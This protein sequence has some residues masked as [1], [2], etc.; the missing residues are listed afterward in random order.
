M[1]I[2]NSNHSNNSN[3]DSNNSENRYSS[4]IS[5]TS[6]NRYTSNNSNTSKNRYIIVIVVIMVI[7]GFSET[8]DPASGCSVLIGKP[9]PKNEVLTIQVP[10]NHVGH[11]VPKP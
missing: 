6:K 1:G 8:L 5:N 9:T 7:R 2:I 11:V 10:L 3:H 4:N